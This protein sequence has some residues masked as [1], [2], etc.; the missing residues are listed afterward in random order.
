LLPFLYWQVMLKGLE[1]NV[2]HYKPRDWLQ[3]AIAREA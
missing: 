2:P 3:E 1:I